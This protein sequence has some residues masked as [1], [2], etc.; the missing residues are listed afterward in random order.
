MQSSHCRSEETAIE[1]P[2]WVRRSVVTT[3]QVCSSESSLRLSQEA[4]RM[5]LGQ[6]CGGG[7]LGT[8]IAATQSQCGTVRGSAKV[9]AKSSSQGKGEA[10]PCFCSQQLLSAK[11]LILD[12]A[13]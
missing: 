9:S 6:T 3:Q 5:D 10:G 2:L 13:S 7:R 8:D 11:E 12:L 1:R 4:K